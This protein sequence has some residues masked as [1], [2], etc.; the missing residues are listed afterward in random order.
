MTIQKFAL[1]LL[2][3]MKRTAEAHYGDSVTDAVIAVPANFNAGQRRAII[4]A[5]S[6]AGI[7]LLLWLMAYQI[8]MNVD[9]NIL[10]FD[11]GGGTFD[12]SVVSIVKGTSFYVKSTAGDTHLGGEDFTDLLKLIQKYGYDISNDPYAVRRLN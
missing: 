2:T 11:L 5:C 9:R 10:I 1:Y 8:K 7:N 6:I 12:V 3:K 4:D